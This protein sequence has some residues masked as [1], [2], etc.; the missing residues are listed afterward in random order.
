MWFVYIQQNQKSNSNSYICSAFIASFATLKQVR[1]EV[2]VY[3]QQTID[4][5]S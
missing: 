5:E 1:A 3:R 2:K 4:G